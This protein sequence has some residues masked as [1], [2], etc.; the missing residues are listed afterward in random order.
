M[1]ATG[2][3]AI[4]KN[5]DATQPDD[6]SGASSSTGLARKRSTARVKSQEAIGPEPAFRP[7]Q[8][9]PF[10]ATDMQPIDTEMWPIHSLVWLQPELKP[11]L[12]GSSN[13][14]IERQYKIPSPDFLSFDVSP[15]SYPDTIEG[16]RDPLPPDKQPQ[17]P[18]SDLVL[19]GWYTQSSSSSVVIVLPEGQSGNGHS[20]G[21]VHLSGDQ[22]RKVEDQ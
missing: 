20:S 8:L 10:A 19:L 1:R 22:Y 7:Q 5:G 3:Q 12:P 9:A 14:R 11:E 2:L 16:V 21:S 6:I 18:Q 13:L 17:P 15:T 4:T